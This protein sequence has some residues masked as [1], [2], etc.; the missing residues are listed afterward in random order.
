MLIDQH[1]I[2]L[3][4]KAK[5]FV[6]IVHCRSKNGPAVER[7][8]MDILRHR[9]YRRD[10]DLHMTAHTCSAIIHYQLNWQSV[11]TCTEHKPPTAD[12]IASCF[13]NISSLPSHSKRFLT[14]TIL[15]TTSNNMFM[16]SISEH[17]NIKTFQLYRNRYWDA[18]TE[19]VIIKLPPQWNYHGTFCCREQSDLFF[20]GY[21]QIINQLSECHLNIICVYCLCWHCDIFTQPDV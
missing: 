11:Y 8:E 14:N 9:I 21:K 12:T 6:H 15:V 1:F 13:P 4:I 3:W 16:H 19:Y 2:W 7:W 17:M 5:P 20:R 18:K 10:A